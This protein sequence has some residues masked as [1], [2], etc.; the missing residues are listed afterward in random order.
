MTED[1]LQNVLCNL[2]GIYVRC[3][4]SLPT[5]Y[6]FIDQ[7]Q[8]VL[9]PRLIKIKTGDTGRDML[10]WMFHTKIVNACD[11]TTWAIIKLSLYSSHE[12]DFSVSV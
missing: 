3:K 2:K 9:H 11:I 5:F 10:D 8:N 7:H 12:C 6:D 1:Y 4:M